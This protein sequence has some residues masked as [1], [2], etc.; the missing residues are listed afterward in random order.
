VLGGLSKLEV[1][2][3][4]SGREVG[5]AAVAVG[6]GGRYVLLDYGVNFNEKDEPQL[7]LHIRP[8]DVTAM[9][10]THAH[11]DHIGATPMMFTTSRVP[12]VMTT[13]TKELGEIMIKDFLKLSGYYLPFEEVDLNTMMD[14]V[15]LTDYGRTLWFEDFSIRLI[16]AGHIPGS[17]MILVD[18]D[19]VKV[20]YTGDV[21]TVDTRLVKGADLRG[22][23]ADILI[24][25]GT[26]GN[27]I[28]PPREETEKEFI[29]AVR[30]VVDRGGNVL[31]PA[32]SL[33]R[34]QEILALLYEKMPDA[35]VYYDGMIRVISN[36]IVSHPEHINRYGLVAKALSEFRAVRNSGDRRRIVKGKGNVIVA[37][38]GML[39]GG[40][41]QYYMKKIAN[42]S[43]N[44]VYLVSYQAPGT[45]GRELLET[46]I[47]GN[48]G[49]PMKARL[50]WFD[51]SSHA[52]QDGL[53]EL[54][55]QVSRLKKIVLVH[56]GED[57][58]QEFKQV[59][60]DIVGAENVY[61]PT[62][63]EVLSFD[64]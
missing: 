11:L 59:L 61:F 62:N 60:E 46:G 55:K 33:G 31:V 17:A 63:G 51:F 13:T 48:N 58:G 6:R 41:A 38:A 35:S 56:S 7:P 3:L 54:T 1:R 49:G 29:D 52:G 26:Y 64:V 10:V 14:N 24:I 40:P 45:P 28:H 44:A 32:F 42:D 25:E 18:L 12:L 16:N 47:F 27:S 19:G 36:I 22:I 21:N 9:A 39:K 43:K 50:M 20:L 53:L 4:G 2:I 8:A 34:S 37:S 15:I 23:E 57:V 30:E 5:R